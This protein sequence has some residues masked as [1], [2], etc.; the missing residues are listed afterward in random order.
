MF[1]L[2]YL[3]NV[4]EIDSSLIYKKV[5]NILIES[6]KGIIGLISSI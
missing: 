4:Q 1:L 5:F 6:K 2:L 3:L